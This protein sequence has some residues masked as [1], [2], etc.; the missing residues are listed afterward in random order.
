MFIVLLILQLALF[1]CFAGVMF[2]MGYWEFHDKKELKQ[3]LIILVSSLV[4]IV[5]C[6]VYLKNWEISLGPVESPVE[7]PS[8]IEPIYE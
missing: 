2:V 1:G 7:Y 4:V 8:V 5:F 3:G 6:C